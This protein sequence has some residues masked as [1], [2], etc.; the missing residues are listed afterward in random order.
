VPRTLVDLAAVL[1][2]LDLAE[3]FHHAKVR[4]HVKPA[5]VERPDRVLAEL[6]PLLR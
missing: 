6:R 4:H 3:A 1:C 2:L 5:V